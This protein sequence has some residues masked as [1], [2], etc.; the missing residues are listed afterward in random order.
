MQHQVCKAH[1]LRTTEALIERYQPFVARDADGS[2][3]AIGVSPQQA[4]ADLTRLGELVKSRQKEQA[5]ELEALHRRYLDAVPPQEGAHQSLAYRT[6][7]GDIR[8]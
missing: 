5:P 4:A 2:L 7:R 3:H 8:P 1:V 6:M